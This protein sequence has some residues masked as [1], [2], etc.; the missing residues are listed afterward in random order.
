MMNY[1][2]DGMG[3]GGWLLMVLAVLAFSGLLVAAVLAVA[4]EP[5]RPRPAGPGTAAAEQVLAD[6]FARGDID[7]EE[8]GQ[9][10]R[11]LRA[12]RP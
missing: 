1:Y 11:T 7:A 3:A 6:R 4:R 5:Y 12:A 9:R 10:L 2:G 8:Y